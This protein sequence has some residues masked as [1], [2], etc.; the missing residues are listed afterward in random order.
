MAS[1]FRRRRGDRRAP[2]WTYSYTD[3]T[4]RR[5]QRKGWPDKRR[6]LEHALALEAE[7]RAVRRGE[8][9][10][11]ASWSGASGRPMADVVR[12]YLAWGAAQGGRRGGPWAAAHLAS[13]ERLLETW[14]RE[15]SLT[16]PADVTLAAVEARVRALLDAGR[17]RR[18][19][20]DHMAA[21]RAFTRWARARGYLAD[22]PL[23]A[24][25]SLDTTPELP[26]RPLTSDE[27]PRLLKTAPPARRLLYRTSLATGYRAGELGRAR[28][29]DLDLAAPSLN[30]P[31]AAT[32]SRKP[33]RQPIPR[34]LADD[35][36]ELARG[37]GPDELLFN[38]PGPDRVSDNFARDREA[39]GIA[40]VTS[41][42]KATFHSLRVTYVDA[43]VHSGADLHTAM[44]L[45]RHGSA[46]MT[47]EVYPRTDRDRMR[48]AA[49]AA[50]KALAGEPDDPP[51]RE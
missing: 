37:R 50:G 31:A 3:E 1:V 6:T 42:G 10:A 39:A 13:R 19:A 33:A 34:G 15:L 20:A 44:T 9:A 41:D 30:L 36:G 18:T 43:I 8:K 12:E 23:A 2:C 45:A 38:M 27:V 17:T 49:E 25:R 16:T 5:R 14:T 21:V 35:L 29:Q 11:P 22:D 28:V 40:R 32:K 26:H 48:E 46:R 47:L 24:M 7:C 51:A 4:G